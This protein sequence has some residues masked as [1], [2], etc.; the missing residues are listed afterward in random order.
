MFKIQFTD[1]IAISVVKR[2][3][4]DQPGVVFAKDLRSGIS[5]AEKQ[6]FKSCTNTE[7]VLKKVNSIVTAAQ[8]FQDITTV[9]QVKLQGTSI[10]MIAWKVIKFVDGEYRLNSPDGKYYRITS[11]KLDTVNRNIAWSSKLD[12]A[13][14]LLYNYCNKRARMTKNRSR[15]YSNND[16]SKMLQILDLFM[17][18]DYQ[19]PTNK[20]CY[21]GVPIENIKMITN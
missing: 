15:I 17:F 20:A 5:S 12:H 19:S 7:D 18:R 21:D 14:E 10:L 16:Y 1:K 6:L 4:K 11:A 9:W 8:S 13:A 2:K 3:G